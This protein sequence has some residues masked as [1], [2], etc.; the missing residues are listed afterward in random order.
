MVTLA[1]V[2][3]RRR[4]RAELKLEMRAAQADAARVEQA[5]RDDEERRRR[6]ARAQLRQ[7]TR[8]IRRARRAELARASAGVGG[9]I[10]T[11]APIV[12][13]TTFAMYG[14]LDYGLTAY[15]RETF[16]LTV[17]V[18]V[19]VAVTIELVSLYVQWHAHDALLRKD[20]A[21]AAWYRRWSYLIAFVV[22]GVN[23]SHFSD[24]WQ[25]TP[26]AVVFA[27]FSASSPW[28]WGLHTRRVHQMQ[29][30]REGKIDETGAVFAAERWRAFPLRTWGAR[31]WSIDHGITD[32]RIA[33]ESYRTELQRRRAAH[34]NRRVVHPTGPHAWITRRI[35]GTPITPSEMPALDQVE[36][37]V[38]S[39]VDDKGLSLYWVTAPPVESKPTPA[40]AKPIAAARRH[41]S[42]F[43]ANPPARAIE[44]AQVA[45]GWPGL[46]D[47]VLAELHLEI[48]EYEARE[49]R[50][51]YRPTN[52]T[53]VTS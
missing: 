45:T 6:A 48:N 50:K 34:A 24:G 49:L 1:D 9:R 13:V 22:A 43:L 20:T 25:P 16:A 44:L 2:T 30:Q 10:R 36:D 7:Q 18:A 35:H 23:Y 29:L 21:T 33:W 32:P 53:Q 11:V 31:R 37:D 15:K 51:R 14:Q 26:A 38:V 39:T 40:R 46:R 27:I 12:L 17:L 19:G 4:A 47:D 5:A 52:G 41:R 8:E 3:T 42:E 28:L